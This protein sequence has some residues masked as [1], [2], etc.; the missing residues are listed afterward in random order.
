MVVGALHVDRA[1][2]AALPLRDVVRDVGQE[3]R[4]LAALLRAP[5]HDA[6]LVVAEV[7]RP[8]PERAVLLVRVAGG[9][10]PLDRLVD[11]A[12]GVQRRLEE[13]D[14][15]LDAERLKV[16]VL[17]LAQLVH[18]EASHGIEVVGVR[19]GRMFVD[20]PLRDLANVLA[21]IAALGNLDVGAAQLA[22]ARLHAR[23]SFTICAPASL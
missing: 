22:H 2:E 4:R 7:G 5:A 21:V 12:V 17:L 11:A 1:R 19:V 13:V 15:E 9:D 18:G 20:V 14:V 6:I 10:E 8:Q 23:A 3:V 16:A